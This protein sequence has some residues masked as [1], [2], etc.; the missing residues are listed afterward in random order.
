MVESFTL[1]L[2]IPVDAAAIVTRTRPSVGLYLHCV[3]FC[4]EIWAHKGAVSQGQVRPLSAS[5]ASTGLSGSEVK[6]KS[7]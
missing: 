5:P 4:S 3:S 7:G 1:S 2:L 6:K